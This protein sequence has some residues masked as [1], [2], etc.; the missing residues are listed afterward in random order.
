MAMDLFDLGD[1]PEELAAALRPSRCRWLLMSFTSDWL[2][3]PFQSQE[4]VDAP[5]RRGQAGQLLQ[6]DGPTAATTPSCCP[7]SW[8]PTASMMRAFLANLHVGQSS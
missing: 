7:T 2:F 4:I 5:A 8:P 6:R 3:P 1:T